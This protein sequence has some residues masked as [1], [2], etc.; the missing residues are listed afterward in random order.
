MTCLWT[1]PFRL[2]TGQKPKILW[3]C[4]NR[5]SYSSFILPRLVRYRLNSTKNL[6]TFS[7]LLRPLSPQLSVLHFAEDSIPQLSVG[8]GGEAESLAILGTKALSPLVFSGLPPTL[9]RFRSRSCAESQPPPNLNP[10]FVKPGNTNQAAEELWRQESRRGRWS[11]GVDD[12]SRAWVFPWATTVSGPSSSQTGANVGTCVVRLG[13]KIECLE[14]WIIRICMCQNLYYGYLYWYTFLMW[15][16][17]KCI[18]IRFS[19]FF[20]IRIHQKQGTLNQF[21]KNFSPWWV[22]TIYIILI[23][24]IMN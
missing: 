9:A 13:M 1:S 24:L 5:I 18:R 23:L 21:H 19:V 15:I 4:T 8:W 20:C 6:V 16:L 22:V 17:N 12:R 14:I 3:Y 7:V 2:G 10:A 11:A